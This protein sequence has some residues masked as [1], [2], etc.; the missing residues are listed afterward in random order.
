MFKCEFVVTFVV[1]VVATACSSAQDGSTT[2]ERTPS[3]LAQLGSVSQLE[4][5]GSAALL[6]A[7]DDEYEITPMGKTHKSCIHHV[8]DGAVIQEHDDGSADVMLNGASIEHDGH[9]QYASKPDPQAVQRMA[10]AGAKGV[11]PGYSGW[12]DWVT[13]NAPTNSYGFNW[14]N[15]IY[16]EWQVP[17]KPGNGYLGQ[18]NYLFNGLDGT[19]ASGGEY[20]LL[21][22]VLQYGADCCGG[23]DYWQMIDWY[24]STVSAH[25]YWGNATQVAVGSY[26]WGSVS[27]DGGG[28]YSDGHGCRWDIEYYTNNTWH[29]MTVFSQVI[30]KRAL[31]G[32]LEVYNTTNCGD[33]PN[34][35]NTTFSYTYAFQ[36]GP[37]F[38]NYN[39]ISSPAWA[40]G[41][42]AGLSPS[43]G[44]GFTTQSGPTSAI[45]WY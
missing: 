37:N 17:S 27:T 35:T 9:C 31:A 4:T 3:T 13:A 45:L 23:G 19:T 32:V 7:P 42:Q 44:L 29:D 15:E 39:Q 28:C 34:T 30:F 11:S 2:S 12:I 5:A 25:T 21:Q 20:G 24:W 22:P 40:G 18:V 16:G 43:C 10:S 8:P 14:I 36:P 6:T 33:L 1:G 41:T 26:V 38:N